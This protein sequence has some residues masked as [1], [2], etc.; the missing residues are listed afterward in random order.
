M[1][2]D[3]ELVSGIPCSA[4]ALIDAAGLKGCAEGMARISERHANFFVTGRNATAADIKVL[5]ERCKETVERK[6]NVE[7][8]PEISLLGEFD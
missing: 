7:L 8:V 2:T 4:G 1:M 5:M 3:T 6:F